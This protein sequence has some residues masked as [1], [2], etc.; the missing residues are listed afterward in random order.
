MQ[1]EDWTEE[2]KQ[3]QGFSTEEF[4]YLS[5]VLGPRGM[6]PDNDDPTLDL[7]DDELKSDPICL[8]DLRV[9]I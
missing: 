2:E 3:H 1:D 4:Q 6:V 5:D 7:D 9:R 8:E